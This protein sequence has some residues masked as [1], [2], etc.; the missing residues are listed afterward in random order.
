MPRGGPEAVG[1]DYMNR[2]TPPRLSVARRVGTAQ[3]PNHMR[4]VARI[5]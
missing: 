2:R 5:I 3:Q 4:T 1:E